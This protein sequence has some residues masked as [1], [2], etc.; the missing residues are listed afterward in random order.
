MK[1]LIRNIIAIGIAIS[2]CFIFSSCS[3][4][5]LYTKKQA[6]SKFCKGDSATF[7]YVDTLRETVIIKGDSAEVNLDCDKFKLKYDSLLQA[8]SALVDTN[9]FVQIY[10]DSNT[11]IFAKPQKDGSTRLKAKNKDKKHVLEKPIDVILKA[12]CD[13][14]ELPKPTFWQRILEYIKNGLAI[15]G[16]VYLIIILFRQIIAK[17]ST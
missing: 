11:A 6:V 5:G 1:S 12:P 15:L 2:Y 9:G 4:I 17:L 3:T 16:I 13:C 14:P 7:H 10:E 8:K